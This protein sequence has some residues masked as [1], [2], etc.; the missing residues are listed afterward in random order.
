MAR[1]VDIVRGGIGMPRYATASYFRPL[2]NAVLACP[3]SIVLAHNAPILPW[4][5]R[6]SAHRVVLYAHNDVLR[7]YTRT[8]ARRLLASTAAIICVSESLARRT[9]EQL[10]TVLASRVRVVENAVDVRRFSPVPRVRQLGAD[11]MRVMFVGRMVKE[12]GVDV[13]LR[14]VSAF[15]ADEVELIIVGSQGFDANAALS[16]YEQEL[17]ALA[18]SVSVPVSFRPFV[19]RVALP[20]LLR[21]ADVLVVP[22]RWAEPSGLTV[23]EG[24]ATGLP[25]IASR[26]GGIPG[27]LGPAGILVDPDDPRSLAAEIRRLAENPQLRASMGATARSWAEAHDWV[28]AWRNLSEVLESCTS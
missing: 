25:I 28:W 21:S 12:K 8:E 5:L 10:P 1:Y 7:T 17:R 9:R 4:L 6:D 22:S 27:V 11:P 20:D 2:S 19:D 23:G 16:A 14:A 24:L 26:V 3:P 13:L 18:D 15:A